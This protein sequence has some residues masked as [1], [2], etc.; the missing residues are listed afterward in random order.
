MVFTQVL[1]MNSIE[2]V[3]Y[4]FED[5]SSFPLEK[6]LLNSWITSTILKENQSKIGDINIIFCSD[7]YLLEINIEY[8]DHDYY[9]D[10]ITFPYQQTPL[11]GDLFIS[12]DRIHENADI[13]NQPFT[14]ELNRVIIHGILH[15]CGY[16][17]K[18]DMDQEQKRKKEDEYLLMGK[19]S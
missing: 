15:L 16:N 5:V 11:S 2:N 19:K 14:N 8:L 7:D 6:N 12:I 13:L 10:I 1:V 18:T 4:F 9:T 17:D 3:R